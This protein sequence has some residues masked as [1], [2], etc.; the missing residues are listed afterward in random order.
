MMTAPVRLAVRSQKA[1]RLLP[2]ASAAVGFALSLKDGGADSI[3][4]PGEIVGGILPLLNH[5]RD[6]TAARG[7]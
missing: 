1:T 4:P 7:I 5:R 2:G 3:T 6:K